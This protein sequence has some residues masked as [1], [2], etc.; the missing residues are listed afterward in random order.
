MIYLIKNKYLKLKLENMPKRLELFL[1][2]P[3]PVL[4]LV[5]KNYLKVLDANFWIL[6][7]K[8]K[9]NQQVDHKEKV[10]EEILVELN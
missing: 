8:M 3:L 6:I 5:L 9:M 10:Q 2:L 7:I 4:Q 1:N